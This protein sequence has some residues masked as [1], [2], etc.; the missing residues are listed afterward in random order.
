[1]RLEGRVALGLDEF[2]LRLGHLK[3]LLAI[4]G[5][6]HGNR[7]QIARRMA[8]ALTEEV[9]VPP[10]ELRSVGD[11][12]VRKKLCLVVGHDG[13]SA[14]LQSKTRYPGIRVTLDQLAQVSGVSW[15]DKAGAP[16]IWLQDRYIADPRTRSKVGAVTTDTRESTSK[17]GVSH[18]VDWAVILGIANN[19]LGLT[20]AGTALSTILIQ[21]RGAKLEGP[22]PNPYVIGSERLAF[23]WLL[24]MVDGDVLVRLIQKVGTVAALGKSEAVQLALEVSS[25]M[26]HELKGNPASASAAGARAVRDYQRDLGIV[27]GG[28]RRERSLSTAWHRVSS[29]LESLTDLGLLSKTDA[30][31][32]SRQY[33]YF[34]RPTDLLQRVSRS[35]GQATGPSEW[36]AECLVGALVGPEE[37]RDRLPDPRPALFDAVKLCM[38]PT[39]LHIDS[40]A[41]VAATLA[42]MGGTTLSLADARRRLT[43]LAI[44]EPDVVRLSRGY[45]GPRAEFASVQLRK[46]E[47]IGA[48]AFQVDAPPAS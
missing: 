22:E 45:S 47:Q 10:D 14:A 36:A 48:N 28:S 23:A 43:D 16:R 19:R 13:S 31:G 30:N 37:R 33:D 27:R 4:L 9:E 21:D 32:V 6:T 39:G 18:L 44:R 1:M 40:Y 34:Y 15:L 11:Y 29:R 35:F 38:G 3:I 12:L 42:W 25:E 17:S 20:A 24:F 41:L 26:R 46:L 7:A 2:M 5:R 8:E